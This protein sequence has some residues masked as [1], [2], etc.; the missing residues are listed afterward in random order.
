MFLG[1]IFLSFLIFIVGVLGIA[2]N[3]Q[4]VIIT[5]MCIELMLLSININLVIFSVYL[6]DIV[7]QIFCLFVLT[8]AA[9][10]SSIGLAILIRFFKLFGSIKALDWGSPL[11]H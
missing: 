10:E 5:L 7:G 9:A 1:K 2:F 3:R 8:V 11:R 6:D 4:S